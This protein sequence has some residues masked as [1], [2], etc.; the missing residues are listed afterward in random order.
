MRNEKAA[1]ADKTTAVVLRRELPNLE[2]LSLVIPLERASLARL[3]LVGSRIAM[4][5]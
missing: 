5:R 1:V 4:F 2:T 3:S